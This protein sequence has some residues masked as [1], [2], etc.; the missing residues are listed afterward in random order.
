M[1]IYGVAQEQPART[2]VPQSELRLNEIR[3]G[4]RLHAERE[5]VESR[6]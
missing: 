2:P 4:A 5:E 3:V 1:R 6:F